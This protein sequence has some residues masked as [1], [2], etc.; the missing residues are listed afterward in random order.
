MIYSV[1]ANLKDL[2]RIDA[3]NFINLN[4]WERTHIQEWIRKNPQI[5]GEEFLIVSM[6][7]DR[8]VSSSDRLDLLALD[9]EGNLVV[10]ELKRDPLSGFADLQAL[11]Y[12]AMVSSMTL[13][14]LAPYYL[15]Y[16]K[17][18]CD[19]EVSITEAT[20]EMRAFVDDDAFTQLSSSPRIVLC[21]ENFSQEITTTVLWLRQ[22]NIDIRC[23]QIIPYKHNES[24]LIVPKVLIPLNEA[25]QYLIDIKTKEVSVE[26]S[27]KARKRRAMQV[28]LE[29]NL[30][31]EGDRIS[32]QNALPTWVKYDENDS[33]FH[34][35]ITGKTGM[36]NTVKW[37]QD[38][39]EYSISNLTWRI[40]TEL[41]PQK[42]EYG[43]LSGAWHWVDESGR[44]LSQIADEFLGQSLATGA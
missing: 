22:S 9:R 10:I 37:E 12:A 13:E 44:S 36:S 23:V 38:N 28:I 34:A 27:I 18:Y 16:L 40:F 19:R 11:R 24:I 1:G 6:E 2:E 26:N 5:L 31:K 35:I 21:S 14:K 3:G 7:F 42:R 20:S 32:L 15:A 43:G 29:N 39:Q 30:L 41:H 25:K 8:F 17:R 33:Q 4:I